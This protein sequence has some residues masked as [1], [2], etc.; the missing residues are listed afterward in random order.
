MTGSAT[1]AVTAR[2]VAYADADELSIRTLPTSASSGYVMNP[3]NTPKTTT[4]AT[5]YISENAAN[6]R[7]TVV[8]TGE[9]PRL[10][11]PAAR[12]V[13]AASQITAANSTSTYEM[14][15]SDRK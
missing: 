12:T 1:S 9:A 3:P 7:N 8:M 10:A 14:A 4:L 2:R 6:A 15:A 13:R 5:A 11:P